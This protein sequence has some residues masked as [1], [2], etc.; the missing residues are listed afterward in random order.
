MP[1]VN[2]LKWEYGREGKKRMG[3]VRGVGER[4]RSRLSRVL[5]TGGRS[6]SRVQGGRP[7]LEVARQL[8]RERSRGGVAVQPAPCLHTALL[9]GQGWE[10]LRTDADSWKVMHSVQSAQGET[11]LQALAG[12]A[13]LSSNVCVT[14]CDY[15]PRLPPSHRGHLGDGESGQGAHTQEQKHL[16]DLR[17]ARAVSSGR[18]NGN[19]TPPQE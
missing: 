8:W 16:H 6:G 12:P 19:M 13:I 14:V 9:L 17:V 10:E 11:W 3:R 4:R 2:F 18:E 15:R 7:Q 1:F 5:G